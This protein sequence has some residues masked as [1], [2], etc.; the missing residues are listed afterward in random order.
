M[1]HLWGHVPDQINRR[2]IEWLVLHGIKVIHIERT[3][4]LAQ[5]ISSFLATETGL[6]GTGDP[7]EPEEYI[8][9]CASIH[10]DEEALRRR[11]SETEAQER[12][13]KKL[14]FQGDLLS[15][16]HE[17]LYGDEKSRGENIQKILHFTGVNPEPRQ[18]RIAMNCFDPTHK[19]TTAEI[20]AIIPN[21]SE[22]EAAFQ[23]TLT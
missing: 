13:Y 17:Q 23:V 6:W 14:L 15:I 2:L 22:I 8:E 10:L 11:M 4:R 7:G 9:K 12:E 1:K 18:L 16:H 19:Q 5:A 3:N 21:I 20:Y